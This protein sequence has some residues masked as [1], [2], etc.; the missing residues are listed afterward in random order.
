VTRLGDDGTGAAR[1]EFLQKG[2]IPWAA[3][4]A[5]TVAAIIAPQ[6]WTS[7]ADSVD[8][9]ALQGVCALV[10]VGAALLVSRMRGRTLLRLVIGSTAIVAVLPGVYTAYVFLCWWLNGFAP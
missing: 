2:W 8:P 6:A 10:G 9:V 1:P 3:L 7:L 5:S 4:G